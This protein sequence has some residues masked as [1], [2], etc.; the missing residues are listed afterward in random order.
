MFGRLYFFIAILIDFY[1]FNVFSS[2]LVTEQMNGFVFLGLIET[3]L[4]DFCS[5]SLLKVLYFSNKMI[6]FN[7]SKVAFLLS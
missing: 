4:T 1:L 3:G 5:V 7:I 2:E 6:I